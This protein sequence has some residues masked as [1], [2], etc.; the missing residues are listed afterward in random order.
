M[1]SFLNEDFLLNTQRASELYHEVAR[2][3][4]IID[5]HC[6]LPP[7]EVAANRRFDNL[8]DI[9]L[10]GDHYKWRLMRSNGVS[11]E[12]CTGDA[13]PWDKFVAFARTLPMALRNP[14]YHW[15]H[16][17][18]QRYFGID[19]VLNED[20]AKEIWEQANEKLKEPEMSAHGILKKFRVAVVCTTDDPVDTLEHHQAIRK[21]NEEG[22]LATRVYPTFR[23][24]K[25]MKLENPAA[26]NEWRKKLEDVS[27]V[28]TDS[29]AGFLDA[30]RQ[31]HDFFHSIGGRLSDHGLERCYATECTQ[32]EAAAIYD[33]ACRGETVSAEA[34]EKFATHIMVFSGRLDADKCWTKQLHVGAMRNNNTR[35]FEKLGPD[36]GFDSIGDFPQG[37]TMSRYLDMLDRENKLPKVVIYNLN[38]SDNYLMATMLGNFQDGS[39]PGKIQFGSGWWFNDQIEGMTAQINALS[40]LGLLGRFVGM[41][42]DSR[43]FLSYPRHEYFRRLVCAILGQDVENGL[44]PDDNA[45]LRD[46]VG[47]ISYSNAANHFGFEVPEL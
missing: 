33:A 2:D 13:D 35:L 38:P 25:A 14:M 28:K 43:S 46:Y 26:F 9:W 15:C 30:L 4:P 31:R 5:Y 44:I 41:L 40:N 27:G 6:H 7:D 8:A 12:L 39:V 16:L 20:T 36:T 23:P 3:L 42:T 11:E 34:Q 21:Q 32:A 1:K 19:T 10:G 18:L 37:Q 24:D 17:E 29:Y 47:R 45:L 22:V